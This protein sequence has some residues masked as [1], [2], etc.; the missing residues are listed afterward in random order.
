MAEHMVIDDGKN[1]T[2]RA[3]KTHPPSL[4][5]VLYIDSNGQRQHNGQRNNR[6]MVDSAM[7]PVRC[8]YDASH[9][10]LRI[11]IIANGLLAEEGWVVIVRGIHEEADE[12]ALTEKFSDFGIIKDVH[13][14]LDRRTGYVK[15]Y[16]LI[17][18]ETRREAQLAVDDGN[19]T[20]FL[21][22]LIQVDFAFAKGP[23]IESRQRRSR[24]R[25]VS[26]S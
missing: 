24:G 16:A 13:F 9:E 17:K 20:K 21:G 22:Q 11:L 4:F 23:E 10:H 18:Y 5:F 8:K 1:L 26:P 7:E 6:M 15:G 19:D 14:N 3:T 12:E 25:S 2:C